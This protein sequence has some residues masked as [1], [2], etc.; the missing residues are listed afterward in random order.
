MLDSTVN[1]CHC[2]PE[3]E[4]Y[5]ARMKGCSQTLDQPRPWC[6][7][8][9]DER[10]CKKAA[11]TGEGKERLERWDWC[12]NNDY[13]PD[14]VPKSPPRMPGSEKWQHPSSQGYRTDMMNPED[15]TKDD[16]NQDDLQHSSGESMM[17]GSFVGLNWYTTGL[18]IFALIVGC[19]TYVC[20]CKAR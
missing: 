14:L 16:V 15:S 4:H 11:G 3:W 9:E 20:C 7:I 19:A 2:E 17:W 1:N 13:K 18:L 6:Y 8:I 12:D 10:L 5:G